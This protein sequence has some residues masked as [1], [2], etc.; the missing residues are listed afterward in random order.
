MRSQAICSIAAPIFAWSSNCLVMPTSRP[1]RS[2]THVL[3]ERLRKLVLE[4]HPLA[5][6]GAGSNGG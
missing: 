3:E 4:H 5:K 2:Y 1:L 6:A